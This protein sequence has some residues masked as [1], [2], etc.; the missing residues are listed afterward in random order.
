[1]FS[2][3]I[4]NMSGSNVIW[5]PHCLLHLISSFPCP[6]PGRQAASWKNFLKFYLAVLCNYWTVVLWPGIEPVSPALGAWSL[7]HWASREDPGG[8]FI[9]PLL[10]KSPGLSPV[11][12]CPFWAN[13]GLWDFSELP[14]GTRVDFL[15]F[16]RTCVTNWR[17]EEPG[18]L[19]STGSQRV[20]DLAT[21][22]Q[23][24]QKCDE[25]QN[26]AEYNRNSCF[27]AKSETKVSAR[28]CSLWTRAWR[29]CSISRSHS[30]VMLAILGVL[31]WQD[32][33]LCLSLHKA[34]CVGVCVFFLLFLT[35]WI[36]SPPFSSMTSS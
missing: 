10:A 31:Q 13:S 14:K 22:Q 33:S 19:Q 2:K 25:V 15:W 8:I 29:V 26:L 23:Q 21:E 7:N 28:P 24:Q 4:R 16:P 18:R 35:H 12:P 36:K 27:Q 9:T 20:H 30:L 17:T 3:R 11:H 34:S 1:M 32:S 6:T 5:T